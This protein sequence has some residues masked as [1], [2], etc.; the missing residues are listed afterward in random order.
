MVITV[1]L[2]W[3]V[4]HIDLGLK[5][6][7]AIMHFRPPLTGS[8]VNNPMFCTSCY[9]LL[10]EP[11]QYTLFS[12]K[13]A[14]G[15][16]GSISSGLILGSWDKLSRK[17]SCIRSQDMGPS[18]PFCL[19]FPFHKIRHLQWVPLWFLQVRPWFYPGMMLAIL[20]LKASEKNIL[21][22]MG[23]CL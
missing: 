7:Q 9:Y 20:F 5:E 15:L 16:Q 8:R 18:A 22:S 10:F 14:F 4:H 3:L 21:E 19:G 17:E 6:C 23:S 12:P 13:S 1:K 11:C 2:E